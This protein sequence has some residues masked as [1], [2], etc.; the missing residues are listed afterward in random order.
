MNF[1][2]K[3]FEATADLRARAATL[4][5]TALTE[6]RARADLDRRVKSLKV[7]LATLSTAG[8]KLNQVA[9]EH[10]A[11]F[12]KQNSSLALAAGKDVS[13]IARSAYATLA[14]GPRAKPAR[15]AKAT[16][17]RKAPARKRTSAKAA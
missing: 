9:R 13:A 2:E 11:R 10:G 7:S 16:K 6:A 3:V 17:A 14:A 12:V 4:A 8:R 15:T 1:Q 5:S